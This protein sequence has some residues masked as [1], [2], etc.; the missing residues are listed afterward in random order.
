LTRGLAAALAA[1]TLAGGIGA[2]VFAPLPAY[3]APV[4]IARDSPAGWA[5]APPLVP[6]DV[7]AGT[8]CSDYAKIDWAAGPNK[9]VF[10]DRVGDPPQLRWTFPDYNGR[11]FNTGKVVR[12]SP[13]PVPWQVAYSTD[14]YLV[15]CSAVSKTWVLG[16]LRP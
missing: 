16:L 8:P 2:Q 3:A 7:I 5:E 14:I 15:T 13:C 1:G 6:T 4:V 11:D 9:T 10:C 12:D